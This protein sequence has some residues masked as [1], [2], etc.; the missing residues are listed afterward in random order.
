MRLQIKIL[1]LLVVG[2]LLSGCATSYHP[3]VGGIYTANKGPLL[4]TESEGGT[5][6]GIATS[7]SILGFCTGDSS[8]G[9][10]A[11]NGNI[12]KIMAVDTDITSVLFGIYVEY[13]TIVRG[14]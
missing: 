9:A 13:T 1:T 14:Q 5:K 11:Q 7:K 10:A 4:V 12:S 2:C 8:I 6:E 3:L